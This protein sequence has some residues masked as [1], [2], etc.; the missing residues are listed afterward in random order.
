MLLVE[1][2]FGELFAVSDSRLLLRSFVA[3]N[4]VAAATFYQN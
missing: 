1:D 3:Q 4:R 2:H